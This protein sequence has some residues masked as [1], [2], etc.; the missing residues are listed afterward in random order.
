MLSKLL[1]LATVV[2]GVL[3]LV[4]VIAISWL[5]V[6]APAGVA[7]ALTLVTVVVALILFKLAK[8]AEKKVLGYL[9]DLENGFF[10]RGFK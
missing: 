7:L 5:L 9:D 3:K 2:L 6:L 8:R 10:K 4:G 1:Y